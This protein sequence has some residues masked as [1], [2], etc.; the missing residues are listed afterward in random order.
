MLSFPELRRLPESDKLTHVPVAANDPDSSTVAEVSKDGEK[1]FVA[2][3]YT[4]D[5]P[6]RESFPAIATRALSNG[7]LPVYLYTNHTVF[8]V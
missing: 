7:L 6:Y 5:T 2:A 8:T 1:I 3:S 4:F